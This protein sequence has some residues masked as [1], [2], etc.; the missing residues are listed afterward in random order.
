MADQDDNAIARQ[1]AEAALAIVNE[2][3]VANQDW[4]VTPQANGQLEWGFPNAPPPPPNPVIATIP[5]FLNENV[6]FSVDL[7]QYVSGGPYTN[8]QI[9]LAL[10]SGW[11]L[12]G[13]VLSYAGPGI[14]TAV[15]KL[16]VSWSGG[17]VLSNAF[18]ISG[19][20]SP[21]ADTV[22]PTIPLE[23][24]IS[25]NASFQP[26]LTWLPGNDPA[27]P[28]Q[29]R[30]GN[31][32]YPITRGT[33]VLSTV[34]VP[35]S[36]F[37]AVLAAADIGAPTT[38]GGTT[39]TG[40]ALTIVSY[41]QDF[42]GVSDAGQFSGVEVTGDFSVACVVQ[43]LSGSA[44]QEFAK[45]GI[46]ARN[47]IGG[48]GTNGPGSPNV[49]VVACPPSLGG[50]TLMTG[51]TSQG[52]TSLTYAAN[53]V[54]YATPLWLLLTRVGNL[55]TGYTSPDG[56]NFTP[57]SQAT[58]ALAATVY[59][60]FFATTHD[61]SGA[62]FITAQL[63]QTFISQDAALTYTDTSVSRA[64]SPQT[65]TYAVNEADRAG[66][67]S[68]GAPTLS[69]V[70]PAS[71][72]GG[73][74]G[75]G[76]MNSSGVFT[77]LAGV[78]TPLGIVCV[79]GLETM[80]GGGARVAGFPAATQAQ[81]AA[82]LSTWGPSKG[83]NIQAQPNTLRFQLI[84]SY[85]NGDTGTDGPLTDSSGWYTGGKPGL[86]AATYQ[87]AV[88][89]TVTRATA[90]GWYVI[91]C[92]CIDSIT[93]SSG[94]LHLGLGQPTGPGPTAV[95]FWGSVAQA[96]KGNR[97]VGLE[98]F[99][100][101]ILSTKNYDNGAGFGTYNATAGGN[102]FTA[103]PAGPVSP[104]PDMFT[105]LNALSA[106]TLFSPPAGNSAAGCLMMNNSANS[107]ALQFCAT[108]MKLA[109]IQEMISAIT[110][111]GAPNLIFVSVPSFAGGIDAWSKVGITDPRGTNQVCP[112]YHCYGQGHMASLLALQ[113]A[114]YA[115]AMTEASWN[116]FSLAN[117][118]FSYNKLYN[119]GLSYSF[120]SN[121]WNN[122][123]A[124]AN[125]MT[126]GASPLTTVPENQGMLTPNGSN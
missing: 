31:A 120:G 27:P 126:G 101:P 92:L 5:S 9:L 112:A 7:A 108:T 16:Q 60:G 95:K 119:A 3:L 30:S 107:S 111:T 58:V 94:I 80:H 19:V 81:W 104:G 29:L 97:M 118:G 103:N 44:G 18:T 51:R 13:T 20:S 96:F 34:P 125:I 69:I 15:V 98:L 110:N 66:N 59:V 77:T 8:P 73:G 10:P 57:L 87:A 46:C 42:Y 48:T 117:G 17:T 28:G 62:S 43:S 22:A 64:G 106:S 41:G 88:I 70:I 1:Q 74:S 2:Y 82:A 113:A 85:W 90:A 52:G 14:A 83:R 54:V 39:Q 61:A 11:S 25:L 109:G 100:E 114:G 86:S 4:K 89:Q 79:S 121:G 23:P 99:N 45:T 32:G 68:T 115:T 38:A 105:Y 36:G 75:A 49:S 102:P 56:I 93:D 26:V 84:S 47:A 124:G 55:F 35:T 91:L 76:I 72:G 67:V 116:N 71:G 63:T 122:W 50:G 40:S 53:D 37:A 33:S 78:K 24:A 12:T 21:A 6:G 123:G 65:L